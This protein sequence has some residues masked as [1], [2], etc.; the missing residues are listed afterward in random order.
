MILEKLIFL[1]WRIQYDFEW[2]NEITDDY[3]FPDVTPLVFHKVKIY[4]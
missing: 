2:P 1:C 3:K 4:Q